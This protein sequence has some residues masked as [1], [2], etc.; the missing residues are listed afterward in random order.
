MSLDAALVLD[1][2]RRAV[3][4]RRGALGAVV[5]DRAARAARA[6]RSPSRRRSQPVTVHD[7]GKLL[8]AFTMLWG[9]VNFSQFLIVWS[10]NMQRGDAVLPEPLHGGWNAIAIVLIVFHFALPFA[11]LLS[12]SLKRNARALAVVAALMLLMQLVDLYW[13]IAPDL[14]RHGHGHVPLRVHWMDVAAV[15]RARRPVRCGSSRG[16]SAAAR[17]CRWGSPRCA[18][19][20]LR[21]RRRTEPCATT[22]RLRADG[23]EGRRHVPGGALHRSSRCS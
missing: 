20:S 12:R 7:L 23:R 18:S 6:P 9:Y 2:L 19:S 8:L 1:H 11:L 16:S 14:A 22:G 17:C 10:G 13:L 3:H 5:H 21:G 15:A 4:R